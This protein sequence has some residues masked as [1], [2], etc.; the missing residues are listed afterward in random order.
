MSLSVLGASID[1][2]FVRNGIIVA[3]RRQ[4]SISTPMLKSRTFPMLKSSVASLGRAVSIELML[5]T[6]FVGVH[7]AGTTDMLDLSGCLSMTATSTIGNK[8]VRGLV[9]QAK[10]NRL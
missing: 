4:S 8:S 2:A 5:I 3:S 6:L 1:I 9:L 10:H 7:I